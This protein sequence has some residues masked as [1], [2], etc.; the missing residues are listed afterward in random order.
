MTEKKQNELNESIPESHE[1][2]VSPE[3]K[4]EAFSAKKEIFS[5][6]KVILLALVISFVLNHYVIVSAEVTS[7]SLE[8]TVMVGDR[9]I[10]SR[11]SYHFHEPQRGDIIV[12]KFPD[13]ES[14]EYLKRII[15]LPGETI[16]IKDGKVYINDSKTPLKEDYLKETPTGDYG[17]YTV[18]EDSYFLMGDNRNISFDSRFWKHTFADK[19]EIIGK[20]EFRYYPIPKLLK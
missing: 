17:P 8:N 2:S 13:D 5:W 3:R 7:G 18:P 16:N 14:Q 15:G 20:A 6:V 12:F 9:I 11:L 19:E 10:A 1:V 4:R